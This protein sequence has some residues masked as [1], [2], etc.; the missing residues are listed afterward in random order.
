[1]STDFPPVDPRAS[2]VVR[3]KMAL[4]IALI[5]IGA[6]VGADLAPR[7]PRRHGHTLAGGPAEIFREIMEGVVSK[8]RL[9]SA[10]PPR[11]SPIGPDKSRSPWSLCAIRGK[12]FL[13]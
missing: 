2:E 7:R 1:M 13:G 5:A 9:T 11:L 3:A 10:N 12:V 4:V 8:S 6:D